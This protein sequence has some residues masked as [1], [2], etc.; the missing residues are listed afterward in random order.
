MPAD[1]ISFRPACPED[2]E[3]VFDITK[4]SIAGL[5]RGCYSPAQIE[6]WMGER[7]PLFYEELIARGRMTVCLRND[8]VIGFVDAEPGEVTRLFVLPGAAGFGVGKRLLDIGVAQARLGHSGPIR[9]E[10]TINAEPF[11]RRYGFRR[12]GRGQFSHGLGGEP[13]EII[14]MEL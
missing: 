1:N 2:A 6:N 11:Y 13:I 7:T 8:V 3:T 12:T 4:A 5:S 14:H 9:L 10:A